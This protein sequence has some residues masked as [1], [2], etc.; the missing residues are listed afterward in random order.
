[1]DK[2]IVA[3]HLKEELK[4]RTV[5][6]AV[7]H[8]FNFDSEFFENYLLPL[9]LPQIPFGENKIQNTILWKKFQSDL[10][11]ITVYC[12][13]HAKSEKG[14]HLDYLVRAIDVQKHNG[15]KPCYHPKHSFILTNDNE[16]III[17]GSN[18][19][20]EA[21]WCSNLEG[22]NFFKLKS[23]I[24]FPRTF[25]DQFK[26]FNRNIRG[27][28]YN[29]P[30]DDFNAQSKADVFLEQFFRSQGYT[31][32][33]TTE[34][35]DTLPKSEYHDFYS[36][37][38]DLKL[39]LN[40]NLP[41]E[42][43][44][45]ISPYFST[46]IQMFQNLKEITGCNDID[47][48]IPFENISVVA[49]DETLFNKV[50]E[51]GYTWKSIKEINNT[52][53]YRFNH[54][55]IYQFVGE[56]NVFT[57]V[58]S[59]NFTNMAWKGVK[60]GGNFESAIIYINPKENYKS[61]LENYAFDD[62]VFTGETEEEKVQDNREDAYKLSFELDWSSNELKIINH[63]ESIQKG[64]IDFGDISWISINN[65]RTVRLSDGQ[66]QLLA[67]N[68]VIK[69]KPSGKKVYFY[70]YPLH[71]NIA[72]KPLPE[73]LNLN[74]AEL[75][76]LWID[77]D[78]NDNKS[79]I[80]GLIDKFIERITDETGDIK[81]E[82]LNDTNSTL[83]AMATHLNGLIKLQ[84]RM[85]AIGRTISEKESNKKMRLYYL[86]ANNV[87]TLIGYRKLI[88]K[89]SKEAKLNDGFYWLLLNIIDVLFYKK[90]KEEDFDDTKDFSHV[91]QIRKKL[92]KEIRKAS[93]KI[94][95][96][97]LTDKHLKWTLKMLQN[98][99]K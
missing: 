85:N 71:K 38:K 79:S 99:F 82:Q 72:S 52:K 26:F 84:K 25:K 81:E 12:D 61:L 76:Q 58:G 13:F 17:T 19:L 29:E 39:R 43:V 22:V 4:G 46:G 83:N 68:P 37:L 27:H 24:N 16:L 69:V 89:M 67:N 21:G 94:K 45:V 55:K 98:D 93:E 87:D 20:T 35:F 64:S 56:E 30:F 57:V 92:K 14:I 5:K 91:E 97:K 42:K 34:Y 95:N 65:S 1:M 32:E 73:Y 86:F 48:S 66:L 77:L 10:P 9:F 63:D 2:V 74:D 60:E 44:E 90:L 75:L 54:S 88:K 31:E 70:Y 78:E 62:L 36:Y 23:K 6:A 53:G 28:F 47:I 41:F 7:F 11:P 59:I 15:V 96:D 33:V 50:K 40:N 3:E 49:L 51:L 8:T 18:N 80:L